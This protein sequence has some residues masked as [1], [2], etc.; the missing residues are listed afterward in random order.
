MTASGFRDAALSIITKYR[1]LYKGS[2]EEYLRSLL[3]SISRRESKSPSY[4]IFTEILGEAFQVDPL[5]FKEEWLAYAEPPL[6]RL[7]Q[8]LL[9]RKSNANNF[10]SPT[11]RSPSNYLPDFQCLYQTAVFQIADLQRF[12][13]K[14]PEEYGKYAHYATKYK[15]FGLKS[16]TGHDWYNWDP[17]TYLECATAGLVD[18]AQSAPPPEFEYGKSWAVLAYLLEW[19]RMYE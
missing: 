11:A 18:H 10:P 19:G 1:N 7:Q 8:V 2:L 9:L 4:G 6:N 15:H 17:F 14:K 16:P 5:P 3:V 13:K 12:A